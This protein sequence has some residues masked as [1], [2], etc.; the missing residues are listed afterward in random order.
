MKRDLLSKRNEVICRWITLNLHYTSHGN[1][2][3]RHCDTG[4][5]SNTEKVGR[6]LDKRHSR[7]THVLGYVE[8]FVTV[9]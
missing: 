2:M 4:A 9:F 3:L 7:G 5:V 8:M 6:G 1:S